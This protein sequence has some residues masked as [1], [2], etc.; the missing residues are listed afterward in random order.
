MLRTQCLTENWS[1]QYTVEGQIL[2]LEDEHF[3]GLGDMT[4]SLSLQWMSSVHLQ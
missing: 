3:S 2:S 1:D 4:S